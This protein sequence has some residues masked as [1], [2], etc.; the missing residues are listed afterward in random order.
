M[1]LLPIIYLGYMFVSI[2]FLSFFLLLYFKN[3]KQLFESPPL[4]KKYSVSFIVPAYNEGDTIKDTIEHIFDIDYPNIIQVIVVNDCSTD[5]TKEIVENLQKK[6]SKLILI[7][8]EKN[9]GNAAGTKN[10]GLKYAKGEVVVMVDA[11]SY[12]ARDSLNKMLGF[13][14]DK[15]V[16]AVT[17]PVFVRNTKTFI[18]KLQAIEYKTI[19]FM[20]KLLGYV[21]AIYVTPGPLAVYRRA[22]LDD[23]GGFDE[24][25][26]T[27]DIEIT[28]RLTAKGW[29]RKMAL[30]TQV[31]ST[32]PEKIWVWYRQRRRWNIGGLQCIA[33]YKSYFLKKG[34]VGMCILPFF[35][36]QFFLGIVGVGVFTYILITKLIS[37][38]FFVNFS[39]QADVP[40]LTL[41][42]L[43]ITPS[44]L[45]YLG[46]I[47]F[48]TGTAFTLIIL[49]K[50]KDDALKKQNFFVILF[51]SVI[52]LTVY[53]FIAIISIYKYFK[54][55]NK[56][57]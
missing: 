31:S 47:L 2:Y 19:A 56:W 22:T 21:D 20:R 50:L 33:K 13:F 43:S 14:E 4:K 23:V 9:L 1:K 16:G 6:Y 24:K 37:N 42:N 25:N 36:F 40:L 29:D 35:I 55:D 49:S 7:N 38:Y 34:M 52:Y 17:C 15:K 48:V 44:F 30:S 12:P 5:N 54:G 53:P 27:E 26:M 32:A 11:D 8:N 3:K 46:V 18:G 51:Y 41:E 39:M 28:W 10:V 45:N 57:W